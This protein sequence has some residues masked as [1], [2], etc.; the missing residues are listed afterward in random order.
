[1]AKNNG[2]S[3]PHS[4][5]HFFKAMIT[6]PR[7]TREFLE[8]VLPEKIL[9]AL[10]MNSVQVEKDHFIEDSLRSLYS[11]CLFKAQI[12]GRQAMIYIMCEHQSTPDPLMP[13]RYRRYKD[14]VWAH[15]LRQNEEAKKLPMIVPVLVYHGQKPYKH[16][17]DLRDLIDAPKEWLGDTYQEPIHLM[18]LSRI[19]D[20]EIIGRVHLAVLM[21]SLKHIY[22]EVIDLMA[23]VDRLKYIR[24]DAVRV[25]FIHLLTIYLLSTREDVDEV[26]LR[27]IVTT[28]LSREAGGEVMTAAERLHRE[29]KKE[30][31]IK[32][33]KNML[34]R[35]MD[36]SFILDI[37]GL[38]LEELRRL[39]HA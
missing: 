33:A 12:A 14:A 22:D 39:K 29:G 35:G 26:Q 31:I 30:G 37:T 27:E 18:D 13:F 23:L 38:S 25:F 6:H 5:D 16:S 36:E 28:G 7:V 1:M 17:L 24:E 20:E 15:Y 19:E 32:V 10:D 9:N 8:E 11:D 2:D 3:L 21:L 34:S 4:H